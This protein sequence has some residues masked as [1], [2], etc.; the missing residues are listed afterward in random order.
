MQLDR[1]VKDVDEESKGKIKINPFINAQLGNEQDTMQQTARGRIDLGGFSVAAAAALVVGFTTLS[2]AA[3]LALFGVMGFASGTAGP[4]RDLLVK[5]STPENAS[6]RVYGVVYSGLDI[7]QAVAPLLFGILMDRQQF[8][9]IWIA[10]VLLQLL[11]IFSALQ[12][13]GA[14]RTPTVATS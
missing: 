4:S 14:R 7:G 10:L 1:F 6:G 8:Q 12:V 13:R 5:R 2:G 9:G 11:L 3:V